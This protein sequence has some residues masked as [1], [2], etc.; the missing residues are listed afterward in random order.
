M[1]DTQVLRDYVVSVQKRLELGELSNSVAR[2][3]L[4]SAKITLDTLRTEMEAARLGCEFGAVA[5]DER[6]R[7]KKD[8]PRRAA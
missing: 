3:L 5:F 7:N 8:S 1:K 4:H 2:T 6:D